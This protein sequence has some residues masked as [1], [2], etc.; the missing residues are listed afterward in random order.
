[1]KTLLLKLA[2][3]ILTYLGVSLGTEVEVG[4][5]VVFGKVVFYIEQIDLDVY[6]SSS[7]LKIKAR[8]V[9]KYGGD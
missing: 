1:M 4:G 8:E 9:V 6:G 5:S 3:R 2:Y 7:T